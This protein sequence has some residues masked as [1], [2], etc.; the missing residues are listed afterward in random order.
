MKK[1]FDFFK[2]VFSKKQKKKSGPTEVI[3]GPTAVY[4]D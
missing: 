2:S 3:S 4:E 1:I